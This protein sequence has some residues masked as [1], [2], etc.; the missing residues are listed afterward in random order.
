M[1]CKNYIKWI[2]SKVGH[3]RVMLVHAGGCIFNESGE[4]LLQRRGDNNKW[5]LPG[6]TIELDETPEMAA[7]RE[8]REETG[9]EVE[10]G[11]L[12]GIY[13]DFEITCPNGDKFQ[14][15]MM[16][17]YLNAVGG[18]LVCDNDETLELKYFP[19]NEIP[20]LCCKQHEEI[21]RD[22]RK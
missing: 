2:R 16:A 9:L 7:V 15:I 13:T 19:L 22:I 18:E 8:V 21:V 10:V 5:G 4:I 11:E 3:E 20:E 6:G 12:I 17:Y 14:S 1:S